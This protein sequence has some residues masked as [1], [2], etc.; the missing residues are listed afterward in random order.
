VLRQNGYV[1]TPTTGQQHGEDENPQ[2]EARGMERMPEAPGSDNVEGRKPVGPE[3]GFG[4]LWQKRFSVTLKTQHDPVAVMRVWKEEFGSFWPE[5]SEYHNPDRGLHPGQVAGLNLD[6]PGGQKLNTGVMILHEDDTSFTF[7]TPQGHMFAGWNTFRTERADNT[8]GPP[9]VVAAVEMTVRASD[10]LYEIGMRLG[11][12]THEN[13]FWRALLQNVAA[14]FG[15]HPPVRLQSRLR[16]R[17][18]RWQ[19]AGNVV[20]NAGIKTT[21]KRAWRGIVWPVRAVAHS[22][23]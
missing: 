4:Q 19:N 13:Q 8:D 16:D 9:G 12:H 18:L 1:A 5:G 11:G 15:E 23:S 21:A 3:S 7:I 10:P 2:G 14:R 6:V 22:I 20:H 17:H